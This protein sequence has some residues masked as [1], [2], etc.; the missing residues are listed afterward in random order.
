MTALKI[1]SCKLLPL[2][3]FLLS[4]YAYA[5]YPLEIIEL[6][7]RPLDEV[8]PLVRS[9]V[10]PDGAVSGMR[11]QLLLRTSPANLREIRGLLEQLDRPAQNLLISVRQQSTSSAGRD[12]ARAD[13]QI[14]SGR[15]G[16]A[17][18]GP[19]D[20]QQSFSLQGIE[21]RTSGE[22]ALVS[23]VRTVAGQSAFIATGHSVPLDTGQRLADGVIRHYQQRT[24]YRDTTSG[25]YALPQI[26][27]E[28]VTIDISPFAMQQNGPRGMLE[29]T[30][31]TTRINTRL[32]EWTPLGGIGL[33]RSSAVSG[34]GLN[35]ATGERLDRQIE[36][37]VELLR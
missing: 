9:F 26:N 8:L 1:L 31:A 28:R 23:R 14:E 10:A 3:L 37:K 24:D 22:A 2:L 13:I 17:T 11:N 35:A 25:F 7:S 16:H 20:R 32:G 4:T 33:Q 36:I 5:D 19:R 18:S 29:L 12:L 21:G 34:I 6:K 27:G 30:A 15:R